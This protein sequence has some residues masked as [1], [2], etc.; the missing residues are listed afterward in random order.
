M[1]VVEGCL[2]YWGRD[3]GCHGYCGKH[4]NQCDHRNYVLPTPERGSSW[5][6]CLKFEALNAIQGAHCGKPLNDILAFHFNSLPQW[7]P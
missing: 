7:A 1:G 5:V 3:K 2:G 6:A 4:I